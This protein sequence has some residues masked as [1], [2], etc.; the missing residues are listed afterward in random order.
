MKKTLIALIILTMTLALAGCSKNKKEEPVPE[1][2][3][4]SEEEKKD[5]EAS[6]E[7][8][9][10]D[11]K[12]EEETSEPANDP[13]TAEALKDSEPLY[14]GVIRAMYQPDISKDGVSYVPSDRQ[15]FWLCIYFTANQM[16]DT[17]EGITFDEKAQTYR[18]PADLM[19]QYAAGC[20]GAEASLPEIP[21][22]VTFVKKDGSDYLVTASDVGDTNTRITK[23]YKNSDGTCCAVID[24]STGEGTMG[25]YKITFRENTREGSMFKYQ[26]TDA[27][28]VK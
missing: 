4:S 11:E 12:E 2:P 3:A 9:E 18:I 20:F 17:P 5:S 25:T 27:V 14:G 22:E 13:Q 10:A 6:P 1:A 21:Q 8:E 19:Q 24:F 16:A 23:A 7:K 15:F 28:L 26:I